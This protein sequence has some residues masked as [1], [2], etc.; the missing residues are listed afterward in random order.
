MDDSRVATGPEHQLRSHDRVGAVAP[1]DRLREL[2]PFLRT[3]LARSEA[4]VLFEHGTVVLL[5][6]EPGPSPL[7]RAKVKLRHDAER[8]AGSAAGDPAVLRL[9]EGEG[10]IVA[11]EDPDV[12]TLVPAST[13]AAGASDVVIGAAGRA[14]H[15]ADVDGGRPLHVEPPAV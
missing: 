10:W 9:E 15:G 12:F 4:W 8:R 1:T 13:I 5:T 14:A 11:S 6:G 7:G 2:V 3:R